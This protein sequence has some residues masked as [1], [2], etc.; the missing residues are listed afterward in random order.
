M[1]YTGVGSYEH[2]NEPWGSKRGGEWL[3]NYQLLE[4]DSV[5]GII[6]YLAKKDGL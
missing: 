1:K 2:R 4:V 3:S 6:Y 5:L